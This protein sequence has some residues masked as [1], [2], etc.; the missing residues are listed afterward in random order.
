M[1]AVAMIV[2]MI[3]ISKKVETKEN[4]QI[5][6]ENKEESKPLEIE[7]VK[8]PELQPQKPKVIIRSKSDFDIIYQQAGQRFGV[9]PLLLKAVHIIESGQRGDTNIT[10]YAGA[11]GPM[12]FI[13]STWKAY[14]IDGDGDGIININDVDD[15]IFGASNY[16]SANGA[17]R[18]LIRQSLWHYNHSDVYVDKVLNK[19]R[20]LGYGG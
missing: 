12:Q 16:L 6:V 2:I 15:A 4:E 1:L 19:A 5:K 14:G 11:Q 9:D 17:D 7:I 10:S 18:G 8:L 3:S 13:P 20:E